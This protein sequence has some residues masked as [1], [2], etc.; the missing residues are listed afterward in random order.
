MHVL[1]C[2]RMGIDYAEDE[3]SGELK[4]Q[5]YK[6][7]AEGETA[8]EPDVLLRLETHKPN[9]KALA[10][11]TAFVEK[12]RTGVLAGQSIPWPTFDNVARPLLGLLGPTQVAVLSDDEVSQQDA[13]ALARQEAERAQRSAELLVQYTERFAQAEAVAALEGIAKELTPAVKAQL[14]GTDLSQGAAGLHAPVGPTQGRVPGARAPMARKWVWTPPSEGRPPDLH[15][16]AFL[17]PTRPPGG[18]FSRGGETG[19]EDVPDATWANVGDL[20]TW[21]PTRPP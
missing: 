2:G 20:P 11:P 14:T 3:A 17:S 16:P 5:G 10:I 4:N 21:P 6:M 19:Q 8:Y 9:R 12:D 1:I 15:L 7:R 18:A 13:D